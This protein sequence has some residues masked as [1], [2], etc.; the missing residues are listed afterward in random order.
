VLNFKFYLAKPCPATNQTPCYISVIRYK[1][2]INDS[3]VFQIHTVSGVDASAV[4]VAETGKA[5]RTLRLE[6]GRHRPENAEGTLWLE[7]RV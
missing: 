5:D 2:S 4:L 6:S 1:D 7:V 3:C